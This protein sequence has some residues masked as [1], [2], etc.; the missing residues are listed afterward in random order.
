MK[1]P[2][3][4]VVRKLLKDFRKRQRVTMN[5]KMGLDAVRAAAYLLDELAWLFEELIN[6]AM[7]S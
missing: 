2:E 5:D 7:S 3:H 4:H 6:E 1:N